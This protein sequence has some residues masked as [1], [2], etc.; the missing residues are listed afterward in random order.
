LAR[1]MSAQGLDVLG[2]DAAPRLIEAARR[3][4][5]AA[6]LTARFE[7]GDARALGSLDTGEPFDAAICVMALMNIDPLEPVL[8]EAA[9]LLK[10]GGAFVGV[11]LHPA[12]RAPGQTAWGWEEDRPAKPQR[13]PSRPRRVRQF[14]RVDGY[15]SPGQAP[16]TMNPGRAA[17]G[18]APVTTW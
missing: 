14:R 13:G 17:H 18:A 9:A 5:A 15:L 11:I 7:V 12:F 10:P 1:T 4:A 6:G 3:R 8:R 2:V 16:I